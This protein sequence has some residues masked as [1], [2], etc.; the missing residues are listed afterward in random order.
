MQRE[1]E[2]GGS[3][4]GLVIL[5]I[6]PLPSLPHDCLVSYRAGM[7]FLWISRLTW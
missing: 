7:E 2:D 6:D 5:L 1:D 4:L 3:G